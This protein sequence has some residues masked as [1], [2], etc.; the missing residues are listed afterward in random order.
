VIMALL[1]GIGTAAGLAFLIRT[2]F[3]TLAFNLLLASAVAA[4][5]GVGMFVRRVVK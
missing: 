5:V 2:T 4:G 3:G 1:I